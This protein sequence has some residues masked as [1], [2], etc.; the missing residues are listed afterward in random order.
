M[1]ARSLHRVAARRV[2]ARVAK[3]SEEVTAPEAA[4]GAVVVAGRE[5]I[6]ESGFGSETAGGVDAGSAQPASAFPVDFGP[7]FFRTTRLRH[8]EFGARTPW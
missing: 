6:S 5:G 7:V 8:F 2:E 4:G 1:G 3:V